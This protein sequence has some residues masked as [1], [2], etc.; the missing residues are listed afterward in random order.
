M[1]DNQFSRQAL[2]IV[3]ALGL[4]VITGYFTAEYVYP[5]FKRRF[6][7]SSSLKHKLQVSVIE[8][9]RFLISAVGREYPVEQI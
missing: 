4:A 2:A 7:L 9:K 5:Y 8:L 6:F 1:D 3:N